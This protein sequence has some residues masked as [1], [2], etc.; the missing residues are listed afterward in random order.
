MVTAIGARLLIE[1]SL[2]RILKFGGWQQ[3]DLAVVGPGTD[4]RENFAMASFLYCRNS[5]YEHR[6]NLKRA[7]LFA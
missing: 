7:L 1:G 4:P 2:Q 5:P 6:C 3:F